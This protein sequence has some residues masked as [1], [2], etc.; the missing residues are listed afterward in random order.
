[1]ELSPAAACRFEHGRRF[2]AR[3]LAAGLAAQHAGQLFQALSFL[4]QLNLCHR[5]LTATLL[6]D[7]PLMAG[8][9]GDLRQ[10]RDADHLVG[11]AQGRQLGAEHVAK[12]TAH[13]RVDF[14][15]D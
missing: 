12:P 8:V 11:L 1:M 2:L 14:I 5:A 9:T 6:A 4:Q 7:R 10:V 3:R 15:E 13:I